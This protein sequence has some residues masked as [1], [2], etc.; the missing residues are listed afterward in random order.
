MGYTELIKEVQAFSG[1]SKKE[2]KI[3]LDST[4]E[5][6][7]SLLT[8]DEREDFASQLPSELQ[9]VALDAEVVEDRSQKDLL[10]QF[11]Q[12]QDIDEDEAVTW[13]QAA[14]RAIKDIVTDGEIRHIR[15]QLPSNSASLLE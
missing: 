10:T 2:S 6:L 3:A 11:I 15:S 12:K 14:W 5:T 4:V 8:E 13:I 1:L 9:Y 7:S